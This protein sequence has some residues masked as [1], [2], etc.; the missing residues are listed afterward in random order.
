[1]H[2]PVIMKIMQWSEGIKS[3]S[4]IFPNYYQSF[5]VLCN[6]FVLSFL[7]LLKMT[8]KNKVF[9]T[10]LAHSVWKTSAQ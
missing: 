8:R 4:I 3:S 2:L 7:F 9:Q 10:V 1:M 6:G 5:T